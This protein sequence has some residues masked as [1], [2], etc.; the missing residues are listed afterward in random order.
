MHVIEKRLETVMM[1]QNYCI[2]LENFTIRMKMLGMITGR[3][4]EDKNLIH[5]DKDSIET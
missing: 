1:Y 5:V 3:S 4:T 2:N